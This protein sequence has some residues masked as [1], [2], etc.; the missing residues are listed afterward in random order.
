MGSFLLLLLL[1]LL[2]PPPLPLP[3]FTAVAFRLAIMASP[4]GARARARAGLRH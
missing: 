4:P 2:P 1:A 3:D